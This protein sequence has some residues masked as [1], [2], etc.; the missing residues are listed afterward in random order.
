VSESDSRKQPGFPPSSAVAGDAGDH[1]AFVAGLFREHNKALIGFL[2]TRLRSRAE[3]QDVAQ[4]AYVRLLQLEQP[5]TVSF[6]RAYLFRIAANLAVDRLRKRD[7]RSLGATTELFED[8]LATPEPDRHVL[9]DEELRA[10]RE[11]LRE[12]PPKVSRAFVLHMFEGHSFQRIA[13]DMKVTDRMVRYNVARAM[14]HCRARL[15]AREG[16]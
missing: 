8:W 10:I 16:S 11:A 5:E 15:D 3:A 1:A 9:A 2:T 7:V 4:E 12:L 14:A 6:L 13:R